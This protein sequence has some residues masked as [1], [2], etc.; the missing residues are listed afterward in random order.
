M[1]WNGGVLATGTIPQVL[2]GHLSAQELQPIAAFLQL[3]VHPDSVTY[4]DILTNGAV[5]LRAPVRPPRPR[6]RRR[7][8][9]EGVR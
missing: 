4:L 1:Y 5:D 3:T 2:P 9:R 8:A 7:P 6:R